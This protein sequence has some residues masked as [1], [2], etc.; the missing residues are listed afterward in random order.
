MRNSKRTQDRKLA[1][2]AQELKAMID[3]DKD[4]EA[5]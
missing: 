4:D 3:G 2:E 1:R 5:L